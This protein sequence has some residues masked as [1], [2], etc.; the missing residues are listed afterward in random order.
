MPELVKIE[1]KAHLPR[2]D[3]G[4]EVA[5]LINPDQLFPFLRFGFHFD[6]D[7]FQFRA[8]D[9]QGIVPFWRVRVVLHSKAERHLFTPDFT[10]EQAIA[11]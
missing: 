11:I 4:V 2:P 1:I 5:I 7:A 8:I 9:R 6:T 3:Y 10:I